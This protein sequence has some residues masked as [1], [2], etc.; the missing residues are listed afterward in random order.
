MFCIQECVDNLSSEHA[1]HVLWAISIAHNYVYIINNYT[2]TI[3]GEYTTCYNMYSVNTIPSQFIR[4]LGCR[5]ST[6]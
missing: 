1:Y 4:L 3:I 2:I 5:T 6:I